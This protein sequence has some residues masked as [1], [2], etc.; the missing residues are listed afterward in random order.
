MDREDHGSPWQVRPLPG[1]SKQSLEKTVG[2][3]FIGRV[4]ELGTWVFK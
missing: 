3:R 1:Q 2:L 4:L